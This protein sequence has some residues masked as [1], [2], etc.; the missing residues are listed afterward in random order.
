MGSAVSFYPHHRPG[1]SVRDHGRRRVSLSMSDRAKLDRAWLAMVSSGAV[2]V[3]EDGA[4]L[5]ELASL[6]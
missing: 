5:G 3:R 2:E 1:S 4:W 6:H